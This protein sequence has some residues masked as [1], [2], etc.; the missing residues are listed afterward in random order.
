MLFFAERWYRNMIKEQLR[1]ACYS[2]LGDRSSQQDAAGLEWSDENL[3]VAVCDGMGGMQGGEIASQTGIATISDKFRNQKP[4]IESETPVWLQRCFDK[5]DH[6]ICSLLDSDGRALGAGSTVV[7]AMFWENRLYWGSVGDSII[8]YIKNGK[9]TALNT[10]HNYHLWI[11]EMLKKGELSP[12]REAA[13]REK[14]AALISFLGIRG[15]PLI[16]TNQQP[17]PMESGDILLLASDGLYK[18]LNMQQIAEIA[19]T[20]GGDMELASRRLCEEACRCA[21]KKQDNTT[22]VAVMCV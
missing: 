11:D 14:G 19:E 9:I 2:I 22:V 8:Y 4:V 10:L 1:A 3:L 16:E 18:S 5:A 20:S 6:E 17:I 7:A 21:V 15:L 13:E 12:E